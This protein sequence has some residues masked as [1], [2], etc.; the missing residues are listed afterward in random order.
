MREYPYQRVFF[1]AAFLVFV[2]LSVNPIP[3]PAIAQTGPTLADCP[4]FLTG[5]VWNTPID[6]LPAERQGSPLLVYKAQ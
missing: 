1:F 6:Y 3:R 2:S 4:V 5:N